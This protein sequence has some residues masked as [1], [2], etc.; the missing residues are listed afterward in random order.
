MPV[1][2]QDSN[3]ILAEAEPEV[4]TTSIADRPERFG[5]GDRVCQTPMVTDRCRH[6]LSE[7][8]QK[9]LPILANENR[10]IRFDTRYGPVV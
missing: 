9:N 3:R 1:Q 7:W 4:D 5:A 2:V 8:S 10:Q 6:R